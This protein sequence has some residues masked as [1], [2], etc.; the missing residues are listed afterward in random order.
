LSSL[1]G[2]LWKPDYSEEWNGGSSERNKITHL[3]QKGEIKLE[4]LPLKT[5]LKI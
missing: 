3:F 4:K 1:T 5:Y 2:P